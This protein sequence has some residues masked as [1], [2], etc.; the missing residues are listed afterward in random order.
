MADH[1][2][3]DDDHE[4]PFVSDS[5]FELEL[6]SFERSSLWPKILFGV[7]VAIGIVLGVMYVKDLGPFHVD[8]PK[9]IEAPPQPASVPAPVL[10][11]PPPPPE[12]VPAVAP[13][14]P[15]PAP[16]PSKKAGKAKHEKKKKHHH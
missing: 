1:D 14:K 16:P 13:A 8:P 2:K 7:V 5:Q 11:P 15:A 12:L 4:T 9:P 3:P 10:P 6:S